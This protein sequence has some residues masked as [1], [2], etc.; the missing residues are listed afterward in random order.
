MQH[1]LIVEPDKNLAELMRRTLL[2]QYEPVVAHTA[3]RAISEADARK[4]DAVVLEL[5][6]AKHNG[7]TFLQ[8]FR[9]YVDWLDVPIIIY[10]QI[11]TEDTGLSAHQWHKHGVTAYLYKPTTRFSS[12]TNTIEQTLTNYETA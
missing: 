7:V 12:L 3:Q 11:P 4:P 10:S 2:T 6:I 5:A 8:E 9:S 1:I